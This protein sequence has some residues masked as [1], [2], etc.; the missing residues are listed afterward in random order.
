MRHL[1]G[2]RPNQPP[3]PA[4]RLMAG[5][6]AAGL[7]VVTLAGCS[8][9]TETSNAPSLGDETA[10]VLDDRSSTGAIE[11]IACDDSIA[12]PEYDC[13]TLEVPLD[14]GAPDGEQIGIALIRRPA[15]DPEERLG[16]IVWNPGGPGG[17]AVEMT[18]AVGD[19]AGLGE[20]FDIIGMDPRGVGMSTPV[21]CAEPLDDV[22]A[23]AAV[24]SAAPRALVDDAHARFAQ[25]CA[26]ASGDLLEHVGT[27]DV[28]DDLELLRRALGEGPLNFVGLSYGTYLGGAYADRHPEHVG[29]FVLDGGVDPAVDPLELIVGQAEALERSIATFLE[30]C[31]AAPECLLGADGDPAAAYDALI[32]RLESEPLQV[33]SRRVGLG[34]LLTAIGPTF[35]NGPEAYP[36]LDEVLAAAVAGD[37]SGILALSDENTGR[38]EDGTYGTT[39][40]SEAAVACLDPLFPS[41]PD[42]VV[43]ADRRI[44]EVAPRARGPIELGW[45]A[46]ASWPVPARDAPTS[47]VARGS[48]PILVVGSLGDPSTPYSWSVALASG[49]ENARL[50]TYDADVHVGLIRSECVAS[51]AIEYMTGGA[52]PP[53]DTV[54]Q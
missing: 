40:G 25:S 7:A 48:A 16:S 30:T 31:A 49:L 9:G 51:V 32:A 35:T 26:L 53:E 24:S 29:G 11:W 42:A 14:H 21:R 38:D 4:R 39:T 13:A 41:S 15:S 5:C 46:C 12:G 45:R 22:V 28:V 34:E 52:L 23:T 8:S 43:E 37:G 54:C 33:G 2:P 27:A 50:L 20:R 19:L 17:S 47:F 3:I 1:D 18:P 36:V 10:G 6:L 44:A